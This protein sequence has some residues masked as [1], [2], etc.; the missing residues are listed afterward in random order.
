VGLTVQLRE[1]VLQGDLGDLT[2][3]LAAEERRQLLESHAAGVE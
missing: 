3:A 2:A 1:A